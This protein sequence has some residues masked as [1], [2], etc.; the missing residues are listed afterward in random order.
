MAC[1]DHERHSARYKYDRYHST[2]FATNSNWL[3][4]F[5]EFQSAGVKHE[6]IL[7]PGREIPSER[8]VKE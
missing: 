2:L 7:I 3:S 6:K 1:Y 8:K 5:Q 4:L